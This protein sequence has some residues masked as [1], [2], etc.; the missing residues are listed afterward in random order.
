MLCGLVEIK[1]DYRSRG[2]GF[3]SWQVQKK[4]LCSDKVSSS[5]L[6]WGDLVYLEIG[7]GST[8]VPKERGY[9]RV[10]SS[11]EH[12]QVNPRYLIQDEFGGGGG[13]VNSVPAPQAFA[14][15]KKLS[16]TVSY[17]FSNIDHTRP[18]KT[19]KPFVLSLSGL[20]VSFLDLIHH[21]TV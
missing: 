4:Y 21:E 10:N 12:P 14:N 6:G 17:I 13:A 3:K 18:I 20:S 1:K 2:C 11:H 15:N 7:G 8:W 5:R 9:V 19:I 16:N